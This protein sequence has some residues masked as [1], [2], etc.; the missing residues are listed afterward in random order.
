MYIWGWGNINKKTKK[1]K[2][3]KQNKKINQSR[4]KKEREIRSQMREFI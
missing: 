1:N 3:K 4:K 2:I